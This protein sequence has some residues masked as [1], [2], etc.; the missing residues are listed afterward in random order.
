MLEL[1][2]VQQDEQDLERSTYGRTTVDELARASR[3][4]LMH[5]RAEREVFATNENAGQSLSL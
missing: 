1:E 5:D 4:T 3:G 2:D